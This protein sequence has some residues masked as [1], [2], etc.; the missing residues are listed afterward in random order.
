MLI[1]PTQIH[2]NEK[3]VHKTK[4]ADIICA[5]FILNI[6]MKRIIYYLYT[7][8][9]SSQSNYMWS[10]SNNLHY[11]FVS[12]TQLPTCIKNKMMYDHVEN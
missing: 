4:D 1:Q 5:P 11:H 2:L 12:H 7:S 9:Y 6:P 8:E 10:V 3:T